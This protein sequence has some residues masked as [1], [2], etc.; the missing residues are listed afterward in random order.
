MWSYPNVIKGWN[1]FVFL[2]YYICFG[3]LL[4]I[5]SVQIIYSAFRKYSYPLTYYTFCCFTTW[6]QNRLNIY[7][8]SPIYTLYPIITKWKHVLEIFAN[9]LKNKYRNIS[10]TFGSDYSCVSLWVTFADYYFQTS[11]SSVKLV[12]DHC[13]QPFFRYRPRGRFNSKLTQENSQSSW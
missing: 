2:K 5:C 9:I 8:F 4:S 7:L 1:N 12:V 11:S 10:F 3:F 6:I 13:W